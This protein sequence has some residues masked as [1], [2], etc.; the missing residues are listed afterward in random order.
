MNTRGVSLTV[1]ELLTASYAVSDFHLPA[2]WAAV[3]ERLAR[4]GVLTEFD[5]TDF[6]R[7][8]SPRLHALRRAG[9]GPASTRIRQP[10]ASC[11]RSDIL[12]LKLAEYQ[13]WAPEIVRRWSG[14]RGSSP[15]RASSPRQD[16]PYRSQLSSLAAIRTVLGG[17]ADDRGG[18]GQDHPLVLVR[19]ARRAV[20]RSPGQ[21]AAPRP[22][23]GRR[24]GA[25][26][27]GARVGHR[28]ELQRG[29][30]QHD[31]HPE[32]RRLQ[33]GVRAA[34]PAG[35]IDWTYSQE[36]IDAT[37]FEEQQVDIGAGLPEGMV[38]EARIEP[39]AR[40][41]IVNKTLAHQPHAPDHGQPAPVRLPGKLENEGG[42]A[43]QLARRHHGDAPDRPEVPA[44]RRLRGLLCRAL[45][46]L[47]R[48]IQDAMG[49]QP[50][51]EPETLADYEPEPVA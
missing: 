46:A 18:G 24:L 13:K 26:R 38:R 35:C 5:D 30:P 22:G 45:A 11:K 7:A 34:A 50:V 23:A 44:R 31:D 49:Q 8:I 19:R 39:S 14:A 1:F 42:P 36:P 33:G 6:L 32:Q 41:S 40:D 47:L 10:A 48:L 21:P 15:G 2:D 29:P 51:D 4:H 43:G 3:Q 16:L 37:I 12:G 9:A 27:P 25:R 17:E 28:G 20:Q